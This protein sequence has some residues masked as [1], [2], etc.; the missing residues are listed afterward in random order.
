MQVKTYTVYDNVD[1][2]FT[3]WWQYFDKYHAKWIKKKMLVN[4]KET[5]MMWKKRLERDGYVFVGKI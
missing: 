1:G 2:G 3:I 5:M 4:S